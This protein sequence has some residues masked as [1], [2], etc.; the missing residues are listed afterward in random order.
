MTARLGSEVPVTISRR[1]AVTYLGTGLIG[2]E[3]MSLEAGT[4]VR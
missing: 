4:H 2:R 1:H 3:R